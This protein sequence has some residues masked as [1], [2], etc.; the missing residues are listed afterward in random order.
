MCQRSQSCTGGTWSAS[1]WA[2]C[3][4]RRI[5]GTSFLVGAALGR[6]RPQRDGVRPKL[7]G[8]ISSRYD[9]LLSSFT[10]PSAQY[11]HFIETRNARDHGLLLILY[12][13]FHRRGAS[14]V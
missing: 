14:A 11:C 8:R 7:C 1:I 10:S 3:L 12:A 13:A 9:P 5:Y 6:E 4:R 2:H